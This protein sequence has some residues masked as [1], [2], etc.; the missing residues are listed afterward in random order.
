MQKDEVIELLGLEKL[1][2]EGGYFKRTFSTEPLAFTTPDGKKRTPGTA[3][4]YLITREDFSAFHRVASAEIY[5]HYAG[6]GAVLTLIQPDGTLHEAALG[7]RLDKGERPQ[8]VIPEGTWQACRLSD[9]GA[10]DWCLIGATVT[11]G[12]EWDDFELGDREDLIRRFPQHRGF[13][14]PLTR[15]TENKA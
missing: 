3:I 14:E 7:D 11:P 1:E 2:P 4:Y 13:I 5:H 10:D 12:F 6:S 9:S 8:I 15:A